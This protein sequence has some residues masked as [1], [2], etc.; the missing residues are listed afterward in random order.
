MA[1]EEEE[2]KKSIQEVKIPPDPIPLLLT[3]L[4]WVMNTMLSK[5]I[6]F[7]HIYSS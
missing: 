1:A 7:L 2:S 5:T 4:K 3:Q 6:H